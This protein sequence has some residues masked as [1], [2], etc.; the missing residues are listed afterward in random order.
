MPHLGQVFMQF[1]GTP[2]DPING[3]RQSPIWSMFEA[4]APTLAY[5]AAT[6]GEDRAYRSNGQPMSLCLHS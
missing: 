4:V 6:M 5:A 2:T 1:V 3:M